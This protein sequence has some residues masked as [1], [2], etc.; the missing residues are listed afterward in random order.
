MDVSGWPGGP[1]SDPAH[2]ALPDVVADLE[3]E[4]VAPEGEG[5]VGVVVR[6][7]ARVDRDVHGATLPARA[8]RRFSIPDRSSHLLHDA[9]RHP[10]RRAGR[11][12]PVAA[13]GHPDQLGEAGGEGAPRGAA[14]LERHQ[15]AVRRLAVGEPELAAEM[16]GR[17]MRVVG[18]RL[19]VQRIRVLTI[20]PVANPAQTRQPAGAAPRRVRWSPTILCRE[21]APPGCVRRP[22]PPSIGG[23]ARFLSS[24]QPSGLTL[25]RLRRVKPHRVQDDRLQ[26]SLIDRV[27]LVE[28]DG[29]N[30]VAVKPCVEELLRIL[31]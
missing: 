14:D 17:H 16:S 13:R 6:E 23:H 30:C 24:G 5:G 29:S 3:A 10:R 25:A 2:L 18:E 31:D 4:G 11:H 19:D 12:A 20:D 22:L 27:D 26:S 7:G 8:D 21:S 15:V 9:R 1:D 28:V